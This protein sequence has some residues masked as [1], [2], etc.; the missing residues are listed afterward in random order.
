MAERRLIRL[1]EVERLVGFGRTWVYSQVL[2]GAFPSPVKL[3]RSSAW[4]ESEVQTWIEAQIRA[5]RDRGSV[6]P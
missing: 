4:V 2:A 3:G 5:S 6:L 1:P